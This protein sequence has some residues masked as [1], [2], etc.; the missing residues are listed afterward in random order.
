MCDF[1]DSSDDEIELKTKSKT[2][3]E[4]REAYAAEYTERQKRVRQ[5][6]QIVKEEPSCFERIK[7]NLRMCCM[8]ILHR[9]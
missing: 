6:M 2:S 5:M 7:L 4:L 9:E 8:F 1:T 3:Q